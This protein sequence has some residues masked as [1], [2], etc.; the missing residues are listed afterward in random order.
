VLWQSNFAKPS[1]LHCQVPISVP[2]GRTT[3]ASKSIFACENI[4]IKSARY[5]LFTKM[6]QATGPENIGPERTLADLVALMAVNRFT[7]ITLEYKGKIR[8]QPDRENSFSRASGEGNG[9]ERQPSLA[10]KSL[11]LFTIQNG[12]NPNRSKRD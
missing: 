8:R 1:R 9:P 2:S 12:L 10:S 6:A 4:R 7:R 11:L 5:K 3:L